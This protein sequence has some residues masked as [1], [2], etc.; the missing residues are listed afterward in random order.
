PPRDAVPVDQRLAHAEPKF[1]Q[2]GTDPSR[3]VSVFGATG[4]ASKFIGASES[5][6]GQ[7][8][9]VS[10]H[11]GWDKTQLFIHRNQPGVAPSRANFVEFAPGRD[12]VFS[13]TVHR[14][15]LYV[16]TN[17]GAPRFRLLKTPMANLE[18]NAWQEI[19][20]EAE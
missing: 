16:L 11:S 18:E 14:G 13:A 7:Y 10:I 9:L 1:H 4:D 8:T 17:L 20:A 15:E 3:D 6:D 5:F 2:L 12:A 19:V